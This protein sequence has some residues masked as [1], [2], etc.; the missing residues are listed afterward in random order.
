[1]G[2]VFA[3][4]ADPTRRLL[5]DELAHRDGQALFELC[6][7]LI[8]RHGVAI[9]RQGV[10]HHVGVLE[11]AGLLEVRRQGRTKLHFLRTDQLDQIG[12]RWK[13]NRD[14]RAGVLKITS[15]QRASSAGSP[16]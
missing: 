12:Q 5:L 10:S 3:A 8:T 1:M 14:R 4:L 11:E 7:R 13:T 9:T 15:F 2:D 16:W 6:T